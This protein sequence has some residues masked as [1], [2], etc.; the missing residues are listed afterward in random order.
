MKKTI[1][2]ILALLLSLSITACDSIPG[3][4]SGDKSGTP[5][6]SD[7][8]NNPSSGSDKSGGSS[9]EESGFHEGYL[10]DTLTTMF[11]DYTVNEAKSYTEYAGKKPAEGNKFLVV[12]VTLKNNTRYSQDMFNGEDGDFTIYYEFGSGEDDYA[13]VDSISE[14]IDDNQF[15]MEYKLGINET[16]TGLL[17]YE[18][19]A[20]IEDFSLDFLEIY[21]ASEADAQA[22]DYFAV[23]F[24]SALS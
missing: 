16:R 21:G 10:G 17:I 9:S 2:L 12:E 6:T 22:G 20:D 5:S 14:I 24:T 23:Y 19:P 11:F 8:S 1:C 13:Y 3:M 7:K 18:V 15:P 4:S